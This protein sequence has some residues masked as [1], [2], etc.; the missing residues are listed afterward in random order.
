MELREINA[1]LQVAQ[2]KSFSKAARHLGYSQAA[3]TIQIKQLEQEL[4]VH[5]FDRIGKQISLTRD[6]ELFFEH[7]NTIMQ[8]LAQARETLSR[9]R[10]LHGTLRIGTIESICTV[11]L[12]Q[13]MKQYHILYPEVNVRIPIDSPEILLSSLTNG[14]L[15]LVYILDQQIHDERFI[16][17]LET[18]EE[19][20]FTASSSNPFTGR[21]QIPLD[22]ILS[23]PFIL[24]ERNA[25]YRLMLDRYL[26][27]REQAIRPYLSIGNTEFIIRQL[28]GSSSLS[29]LPSFTIA[30]EEKKGLLCALDVEQFHMQVWRQVL[31]HKDKWVTREM[32]A[33][34]QLLRSQH[35]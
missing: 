3:I 8:E 16:K 26:A 4:D 24:T 23:Q 32:E 13:V 6:G 18:P 25:S 14:T 31:H 1:F 12:P 35:H 27:A 15:D 2:F 9:D 28:I 33:F 19:A 10:K 17:V 11:L 7:A 21:Q 34:F 29:F 20:V 5:L 30:P 22:E